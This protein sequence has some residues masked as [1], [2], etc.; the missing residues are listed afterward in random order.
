MDDKKSKTAKIAITIGL[1]GLIA[2]IFLL[3]SGENL[4]GISGSVACAAL[5]MKGFYDLRSNGTE[6]TKQ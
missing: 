4:I 5:V 1:C 3:F 6:G 2:G